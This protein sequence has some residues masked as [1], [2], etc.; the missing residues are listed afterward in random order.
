ML[1]IP[2]GKVTLGSPKSEADR[3]DDEGPQVEVEIEPFYMGKYELTQA[4]YDQF[5]SRYNKVGGND[6]QV[7]PQV[8]ADK[9]AD[10]VTYPTPMY[11]LEAGPIFQRMG[12]GGQFPAVI[13]SQYA[14]REYTKWLSKK[15]GRF[16]RLPTEAEW[17]H[18][19]RAGTKTAYYF[20]DDPKGLDEH[21]WY[22]DNSDLKGE[23]AYREVGKKKP[24]PWG[25]YDIHGNVAELVI[26]QYADDWYEKLKAKGATVKWSDAINWP[27]K[28]YP[29][30]ARGGG[31]ESDA[32]DLRAARRLELKPGVNQSDPQ[33][34]K[35]PHW[36]SDG[37][38][39]GMRLV[40]PVKEPSEE[41]KRKF[42]EPDPGTAKILEQAKDK[43][44][45]ELV[46]PPNKAADAG[47]TNK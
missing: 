45:R 42:W 43:Q 26:D 17:E 47:G 36:Y 24:N 7:R 35:S 25:L 18:A 21:A 1:P 13:M 9:L 11:E 5:R 20:G 31:Y 28:Q 12:R 32:E 2:G 27:T 29:K 16:Y 23:A 10:A 41:E 33:L 15:T 34:P 46:V 8:P 19:A 44:I 37:F 40:S 3:Q 38:W 4:E 14:A 6:G 39:V 30:L 22:F